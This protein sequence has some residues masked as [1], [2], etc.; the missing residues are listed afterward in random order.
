MR[1]ALL[2]CCLATILLTQAGCSSYRLRDPIDLNTKV[3]PF[4]K[5]VG[6]KAIENRCTERE[7]PLKGENETATVC[8]MSAAIALAP[9]KRLE[10]T[11]LITGPHESNTVTASLA[12]WAWDIPAGDSKLEDLSRSDILALDYLRVAGVPAEYDTCD[13]GKGGGGCVREDMA[14]WWSGVQQTPTTLVSEL[15]GSPTLTLHIIGK[16]RDPEA[17]VAPTVENLCS[18]IAKNGSTEWPLMTDP[19]ETDATLTHAL[20]FTVNK[21][22]SERK[23]FYVFRGSNWDYSGGELHKVPDLF[24]NGWLLPNPEGKAV[25]RYYGRADVSISIPIQSR[26]LPIPD[27]VPL[28]TSLEKVAS[29]LKA[30]DYTLRGVL[31]QCKAIDLDRLHIQGKTGLKSDY[32]T[33]PAEAERAKAIKLACPTGNSR[34]MLRFAPPGK[35]VSGIDLRAGEIDLPNDALEKLLVTDNDAFLADAVQ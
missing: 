25:P 19:A 4:S 33:L 34:V 2:S 35:K 16:D 17:K 24:S 28:C 30:R 23:Q 9:P 14:K 32:H 13:S 20:R 1:S 5:V 31:R 12:M 8:D 22:S 7:K 26:G 6:G 3:I 21:S 18:G 29:L 10:V 15:F 27:H 11:E